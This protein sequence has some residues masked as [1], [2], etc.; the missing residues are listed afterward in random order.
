MAGQD[1][2]AVLDAERALEQALDQIAP[3]AKHGDNQSQAYP[4]GKRETQVVHAMLL[5]DIPDGSGHSGYKDESA[6]GPLPALAR[7]DAREQLV[8]A[9]E[10]AA[11]IGSGVI[12]PKEHEDAEGSEVGVDD[13]GW[14]DTEGQY[15]DKRQRQGDIQLAHHGV[16]PVV[17]RVWGLGI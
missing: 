2:A 6:D 16:G 15:A 1:V 3:C 4:L 7:A 12:G 10:R 9:K 13:A 8:P 11:A 17:H 5:G 14:R